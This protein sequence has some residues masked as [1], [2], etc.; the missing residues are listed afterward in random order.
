MGARS[1]PV[2]WY[3]PSSKSQHR[4]RTH[5]RT[6]TQ[7]QTHQAQDTA[8]TQTA[9]THTSESQPRPKHT[10]PTATPNRNPP[11][12]PARRL[13]PV[14]LSRGHDALLRELHH[15][16]RQL[17]AA[18]RPRALPLRVALHM[19]TAAGHHPLKS[20]PRHEAPPHDNT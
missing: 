5:A 14:A 8:D 20:C 9:D 2:A 6:D 11:L 19:P 12:T 7:R 10:Q 3:C 18:R 13:T 15:Q 17:L 1:V 16:R 4:D